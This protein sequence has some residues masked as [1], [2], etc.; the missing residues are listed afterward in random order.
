MVNDYAITYLSIQISIHQF[1]LL[2]VYFVL[3][4][5]AHGEGPMVPYRPLVVHDMVTKETV[6]KVTELFW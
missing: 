6:A 2:T 1:Q 3:C 5:M 4:G